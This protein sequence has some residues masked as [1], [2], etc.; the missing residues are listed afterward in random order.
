MGGSIR[1]KGLKVSLGMIM[2]LRLENIALDHKLL[3]WVWSPFGESDD[4]TEP[5]P[6]LRIHRIL[7]IAV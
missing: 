1:K 4:D 2:K 7:H 5:A 6:R 3:I